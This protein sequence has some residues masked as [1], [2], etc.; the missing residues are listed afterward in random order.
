[1]SAGINSVG[2]VSMQVWSSQDQREHR[3]IKDKKRDPSADGG[4]GAGEKNRRKKK[5]EFLISNK[6]MVQ[7]LSTA[8]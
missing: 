6:K 1:M 4:D 5:I 2:Q 8:K 3:M 7:P